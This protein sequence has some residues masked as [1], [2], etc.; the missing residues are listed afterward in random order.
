MTMNPQHDLTHL[1]ERLEAFEERLRVRI[2]AVYARRDLA[3][4]QINF[5]L[6]PHDGVQLAQNTE[7]VADI[8][9][10][11]R[12][13]IGR[14]TWTFLASKFHGFESFNLR[15]FVGDDGEVFKIRLYPKPG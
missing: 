15:V 7:I 13:L 14:A 9:D 2:E 11:A 3:Y 5:E 12:R 1:V 4:I 6:H 8:Y 10:S